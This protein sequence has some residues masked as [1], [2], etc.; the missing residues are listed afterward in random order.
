MYSQ[1]NPL[2]V[3]DKSARVSSEP[4]LLLLAGGKSLDHRLTCHRRWFPCEAPSERGLCIPRSFWSKITCASDRGIRISPLWSLSVFWDPSKTHHRFAFCRIG[5]M[6]ECMRQ[7]HVGFLLG[8]HRVGLWSW[9]RNEFAVVV[10][11]SVLSCV[12]VYK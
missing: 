9:G 6:S 1:L 10:T 3:W 5:R 8:H 11:K 2:V 7:C 4:P 12:S